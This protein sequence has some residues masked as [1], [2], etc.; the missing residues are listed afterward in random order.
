MREVYVIRQGNHDSIYHYGF[1]IELEAHQEVQRLETLR[2]ENNRKY[3]EWMQNPGP[4][5]FNGQCFLYSRE[6]RVWSYRKV[7]VPEEAYGEIRK[8]RESLRESK[9]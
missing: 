4:K 6:D 2:L 8:R 1:H 7:Q 3:E 5:S 9:S